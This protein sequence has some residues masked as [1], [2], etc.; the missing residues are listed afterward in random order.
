MRAV[1]LLTLA[2]AAVAQAQAPVPCPPASL[3]ESQVLQ[4]VKD[5]VPDGRIVQV[6]GACHIG[7]FPASG[8]LDRLAEAGASETVLEAVRQDGLPRASVAEA[9]QEVASLERKIV[10]LTAASNAERDRALNQLDADYRPQ[11][12]GAAKVDPQ[13]MFEKSA[14]YAARVAAAK[15]KLAELERD[16]QAARERTA[17]R[18]SGDLA[19]KA[20]PIRRQIDAFV[21]GRT[22]LMAGAKLDFVDYNADN[23]RL[24]AAVNGEAYWFSVPVDPAKNL[25]GRWS[26]AALSQ[27]FSED[28]AHTRYLV[29]TVTDAHFPGVPKAVG[30]ELERKE[31]ADRAAAMAAD[32]AAAEERRKARV[33]EFVSIPAGEFVMGSSSGNDEKPRHR[34]RITKGFEIG[35]TVVTQAQW[36]A[37]MG[38]NP[39][40][41]TGDDRPVENVSWN[42]V[43]RFLERVNDENDG[44]RYRLPT[45]AEW[46]YA[47][48]AGSTADTVAD[49][50]AVAWF[51]ANSGGETHPVRQKQANAWGLYDMLGN[52][53]EWCADW[54]G[55]RY[56]ASSPADDPQGP[57]SGTTRVVR[58]GSWYF[59]GG[60]VRPAFRYRIIPDVRSDDTGF[61]LVREAR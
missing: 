58:G 61:R 16:R 40:G 8:I 1:A 49:G 59:T 56:Y 37:V 10:S 18:Y 23:D 39:S 32:A 45:E 3:T 27:A 30:E 36:R 5:R 44:Y 53:W 34:V 60:F 54:Y 17:A 14:D 13:G 50:K 6:V 15:E 25:Y 52:V 4:L 11:I 21:K 19:D 20:Q 7:F 2:F 29:D 12:E 51:A 57:A 46:E 55:A 38:A 9:R 42:D 26:K 43:Q 31:A 35:R 22:Y 41:F 47:A 28:D 24:L 48:R 33:G